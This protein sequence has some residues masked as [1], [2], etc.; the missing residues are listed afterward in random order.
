MHTQFSR[1]IQYSIDPSPLHI[2]SRLSFLYC[3]DTANIED[4]F[5]GDI[6][7]T[8]SQRKQMIK[9]AQD[10]EEETE[11]EEKEEKEKEEKEGEGEGHEV[12][13]RAVVKDSTYKWPNAVIPYVISSSLRKK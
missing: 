10:G 2:S 11:E 6:I 8:P 3:A 13:A 5:E 7:L 1:N 4:F 12:R 9:E